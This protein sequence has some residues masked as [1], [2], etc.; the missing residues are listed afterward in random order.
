MRTEIDSAYSAAPLPVDAVQTRTKWGHLLLV[1]FL[2]LTGRWKSGI[3]TCAFARPCECIDFRDHS[4]VIKVTAVRLSPSASQVTV[5]ACSPAGRATFVA[6]WRT[7]DA[8]A[9]WRTRSARR[10]RS[11]TR[12]P[13]RPRRQRTSAVAHPAVERTIHHGDAPREDSVRDGSPATAGA[14]STGGVQ[15]SCCVAMSRRAARAPRPAAARRPEGPG[16]TR[17]QV[18]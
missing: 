15:S 8:R 17:G 14:P 3:R 13:C 11:R 4:L 5:L 9:C 10:S 12:A 6:S 2:E 18:G 7:W 1:P 16:S